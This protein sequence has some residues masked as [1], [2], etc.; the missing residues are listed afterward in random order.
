MTY[1]PV[2]MKCP[3]C[4]SR[5]GKRQC[6]VHAGAICSLCCGSSRQAPACLGCTYFKAPIRKYDPLPRF[7]TAEMEASEHLQEISF[8]IEA[9]VCSFDRQRNYELQDIQA[10]E[11][12]EVLLDL[13]AFGDTKEAIV[14][15]ID[16]LGCG[17]AVDLVQRELQPFDRDVIAKVI[18]TVRYVAR[19]RAAGGRH[20]MEVLH[21]YCGAFV[22]P[23]IGLRKLD[24]GVEMI[25]GE[26]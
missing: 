8:P 19:R 23:G 24:D 17:S 22:R 14:D 13:Y 16:A 1:S 4:T 10:I 6:Q 18:A 12:F 2:A 26:I 20:H 5:K 15:R 9:A 21:K 25:F 11:I 7:S 3:L